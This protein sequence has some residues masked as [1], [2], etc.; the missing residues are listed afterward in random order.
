MTVEVGFM[1]SS[2]LEGVR[3]REVGAV[4]IT[5]SNSQEEDEDEE[6]AAREKKGNGQIFSFLKTKWKMAGGT[7]GKKGKEKK[8]DNE[9]GSLWALL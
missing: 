9:P 2:T 1:V 7:K 8:I 3:R 4:F 5:D 6:E